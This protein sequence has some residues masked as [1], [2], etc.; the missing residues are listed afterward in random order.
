M[1]LLGG[2]GGKGGGSQLRGVCL[3]YLGLNAK[4]RK[5]LASGGSALGLKFYAGH[6]KRPAL[7]PRGACHKEGLGAAALAQL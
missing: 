4:G 1:A 6:R 7:C 3:N 5:A 2:K